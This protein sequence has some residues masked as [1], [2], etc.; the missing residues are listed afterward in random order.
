MPLL[1][2]LGED[3]TDFAWYARQMAPSLKAELGDGGAGLGV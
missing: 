2:P 3:L 1:L